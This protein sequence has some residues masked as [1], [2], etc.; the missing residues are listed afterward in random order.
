[1][2]D[3]KPEDVMRALECCSARHCSDSEPSTRDCPLKNDEYC[4]ST[5]PQ[6]AL[7]LLRE[8]D[9][10][11]ERLKEDNETLIHNINQAEEEAERLENLL[12]NSVT[13][14]CKVGDTCYMISRYYG[15]NFEIYTC[16]VDH[17]SIYG[18]LVFLSIYDQKDRGKSFGV[19]INNDSLFFDLY[20]AQEYL[21]TLEER[22]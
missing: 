21:K 20:K 4:G 13:L 18:H 15:G 11:I 22:T 2:N 19:E 10:E 14:P 1:M 12:A 6:Y 3:L 17:I 9:A 5:L 16:T 8:K 7:A